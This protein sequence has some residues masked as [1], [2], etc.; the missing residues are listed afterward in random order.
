MD[1][2]DLRDRAEKGSGVAQGALGLAYLFGHEV[3]VDH[4]Q[5][6]R[7]LSLAA[8]RG[9]AR[10]AVW[11]GT[12]YEHGLGLPVDMKRAWQLYEYGAERGE[13][14][15]CI[16]LARLLATGKG[17]QMDESAAALWYRRALS[18]EVDA[19]AVAAEI[20]EATLYLA[21]HPPA[22]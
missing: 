20:K 7:R 3:P 9:A 1:I 22:P 6:A 19:V 10:P 15:G 16:L 5:A 8:E 11:L 21:S 2:D 4:A 17:S 18:L 12:M 13:F 14:D